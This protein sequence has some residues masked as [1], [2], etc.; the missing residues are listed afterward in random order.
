MTRLILLAAVGCWA[1]MAQSGEKPVRLYGG[2]GAWSHLIAT[3]NAEA[4]KYFDQGL[5]LT[6]GFNRYEG[7]RSFR[8]AAELDPTA[9]MPYWG[10]AMALGPYINMD[11]DASYAIRESCA[12]VNEGLALTKVNPAEHAWLEAAATRCPDFAEPAKYIEAMKDLA[13][14]YPDDLDA[15]VLYADS[16]MIPTRWH[17]YSNAGVPAPGMVEAEHALEAVMRRNANHPGANH[18]YI[19]A[20]ES[21][22]TPERAVPSAQRLMGIV[23]SEGHMVHMPGH[24]WLVAGDFEMT[25]TVNEK[26]VEADR[27]YFAQT[28]VKAEA[29]LSGSYYGYY[30]HNIQF[31]LYA[32]S[33]QGRTAATLATEK[34]LRAAS[35]AAIATMP[36]MAGVLDASVK[37]A[38]L[39]INRWDQLISAPKPATDDKL[40]LTM[41]SY[42]RAL[43]LALKGRTDEARKDAAVFRAYQATLDPKASWGQNTTGNVMALA[44]RILDARIARTPGEALSLWKSAVAMQ[45]ALVYD[46]PPAWY[47]PV[48]ESWGAATLLAGDAAAAEV[49]FHEGLRRSPNNGRMLFGLLESLK[50]QGKKDAAK[51]VQREFDN[52]WAGADIKLKLAEL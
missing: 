12:A 16:L 25:A 7:L 51:Q 19:H 47:Y 5:S 4:Q 3:T 13:A 40:T 1:L 2:T 38:E 32:R 11:G 15:Q 21:S 29:G 23:P 44:A 14:K 37:M 48:R 24:I 27:R 31:I 22:L 39:R 8:H 43:S 35:A 34:E 33:M 18:L 30:L 41:W 6:Y 36:E 49:V 46:E 17:W 20:V 26:A 10:I 45:D 52:A 50:A 42:C 28:G 9:P